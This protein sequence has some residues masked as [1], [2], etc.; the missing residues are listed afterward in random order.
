MES[1]Y[2][3][4]YL[5][6]C[7]ADDN[8]ESDNDGRDNGWLSDRYLKD[9]GGRSKSSDL[10]GGRGDKGRRG[11]VGRVES[12]CEGGLDSNPYRRSTSRYGES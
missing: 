8:L 10:E 2:E 1:E 3:E 12:E 6:G 4:G 5:A 7:C 9:C 11:D